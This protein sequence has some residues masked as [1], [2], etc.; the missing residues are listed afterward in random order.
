MSQ[1]DPVQIVQDLPNGRGRKAFNRTKK[2]AHTIQSD[3]CINA[4]DEA[5]IVTLECPGDNWAIRITEV[6]AVYDGQ[7]S[8]ILSISDGTTNYQILV[9]TSLARLRFDTTRWEAGKDLTVTLAA[10]GAIGYLNV[11]GAFA[12]R[13]TD[14]GPTV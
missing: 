11:V 8:G 9:T 6:H 12:E 1:G 4:D 5:R 14:P 2:E 10:G 3:H 7:G 13:I